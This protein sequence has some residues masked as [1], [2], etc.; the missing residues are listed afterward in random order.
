MEMD[1]SEA[2]LNTLAI[3]CFSLASIVLFLV[4]YGPPALSAPP[5][6]SW[7]PM[8]PL[9]LIAFVMGHWGWIPG[10]VMGIRQLFWKPRIYGIYII[11]IGC[12]QFAGFQ[13][14]EWLLM[15]SRGITWGS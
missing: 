5:G 13:L 15:D 9:L 8:T 6:T 10:I 3:G 4:V 11:G 7:R 2:R 12:A 14:V 1:P